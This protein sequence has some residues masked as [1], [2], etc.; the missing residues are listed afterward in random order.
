MRIFFFFLFFS[1]EKQK[2][3]K[4]SC[5]KNRCR[6]TTTV[7]HHQYIQYC[8]NQN[9]NLSDSCLAVAIPQTGNQLNGRVYVWYVRR[10][11]KVAHICKRE[12]NERIQSIT[13]TCVTADS[14]VWK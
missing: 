8:H 3:K 9:H 5:H 11:R 12:Q 14:M 4:K 6:H 1:Y 13:Y 2:I 10:N 7:I